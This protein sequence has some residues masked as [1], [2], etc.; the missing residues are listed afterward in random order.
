MEH[1]F[2]V[3]FYFVLLCSAVLVLPCVGVGPPRVCM[4][5]RSWA[6][7][8][9]PTRRLLSG[10]SPLKKKKKKKEKCAK[11]T[12]RKNFLFLCSNNWQKPDTMIS[13][14]PGYRHEQRMPFRNEESPS[15]NSLWISTACQVVKVPGWVL[16]SGANSVCILSTAAILCFCLA[17]ARSISFWQVGENGHFPRDSTPRWA[18]YPRSPCTTGWNLCYNISQY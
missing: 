6:H 16:P 7:L 4:G 1:A 8:P 12:I 11:D 18:Q 15:W 9:P 14:L 13:D 10:S 3:C 2:L 5:S 17:T